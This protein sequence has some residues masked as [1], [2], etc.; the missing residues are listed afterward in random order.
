M[1]GR[2]LT[3]FFDD[4][5]A[6]SDGAAK[7]A[8]AATGRSNITLMGDVLLDEVA[9]RDFDCVFCPGNLSVSRV[10]PFCV[11]RRVLSAHCVAQAARGRSCCARTPV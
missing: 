4:D 1:L 7:G 6:K 10:C 8:P 9:S 5:S 2:W 11:L 3:P